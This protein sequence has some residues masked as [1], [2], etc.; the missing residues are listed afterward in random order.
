MIVSDSQ[1]AASP[2][3][4]AHGTAPWKLSVSLVLCA[5]L[6]LSLLSGEGVASL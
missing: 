3:G 4:C 1:E 5:R 2:P 6:D